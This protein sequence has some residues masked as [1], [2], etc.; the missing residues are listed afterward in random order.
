M[1]VYRVVACSHT[2]HTC[3]AWHSHVVLMS[4]TP[5]PAAWPQ[6]AGSSVQ[7][8]LKRLEELKFKIVSSWFR[9][10]PPFDLSCLSS[11]SSC[12]PRRQN[13]WNPPLK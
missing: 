8:V 11:A 3:R 1:P 4:G 6:V 10:L 12:K 9:M 7:S 5:V 2:V 13:A